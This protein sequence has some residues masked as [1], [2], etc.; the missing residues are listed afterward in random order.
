MSSGDE[1]YFLGRCLA[2]VLALCNAANGNWV[3]QAKHL[4]RF[5]DTR[6]GFLVDLFIALKKDPLN[7]DPF[8]LGF[9]TGLTRVG[10]LRRD[11]PRHNGAARGSGTFTA[12][13]TG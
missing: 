2:V 7:A 8:V 10:V 5:R 9:T 3:Q 1:N 6:D 13:R 12:D 4:Y 11:H